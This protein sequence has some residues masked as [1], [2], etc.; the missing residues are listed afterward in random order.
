LH[1]GCYP[2]AMLR[3][4]WHQR[5]SKTVQRLCL[6]ICWA[7]NESHIW[8]GSMVYIYLLQG[9]MQAARGVTEPQHG[10]PYTNGW[11]IWENKST[12]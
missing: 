4:D 1:Q 9:A 8:Q 10:I 6:P 11:I 7:P 5:S 3:K 2:C 12:C